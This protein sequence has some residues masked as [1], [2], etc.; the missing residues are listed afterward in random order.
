MR[1]LG[2]TATWSG[3]EVTPRAQAVLAPNPGWM[4]LDG[5]NSWLLHEPGATEAVLVDPGPDDPGHLRALVDAAATR[6]ARITRIVL[7]HG[8]HDHAEG[9]SGLSAMTGAPVL[10]LDPS[11]RLGS[12]G[13]SDGDVLD[14]GGLELRVVATPGH[15]RD[16]LSLLLPADGAILTGDTVLGRGTAVIAHPDGDLGDYLD[17]LGRL[18]G[19]IEEHRMDWLLPGHGPALDSAADLLAGYRTHREARLALVRAAW[20]DGLRDLNE[21]LDAAYPEVG[22][23]LRWAA[24]L[25]LQA[26]VDYLATGR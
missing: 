25:S 18:S 4:T 8:H 11:L 22:P 20:D 26:Q 23:E 3:G 21:L 19:L 5:T 1:P 17:T 14:T 9:A 13:L 6:D 10:A 7:T 24:R 2:S 12:E 16:S 15:T